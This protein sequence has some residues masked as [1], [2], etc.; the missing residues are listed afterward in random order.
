MLPGI[1][2]S[3]WNGA[4]DW[5]TVVSAGYKFAYTKATDSITYT[6]DTLAPNA[7]GAAEAGI[8][9]GAYHFYR[10]AADAKA[11]AEYFLAKIK[12]LQMEMP[13]VLDF[14]EQASFPHATVAKSLKL[15]LD[16][17]EAGTG[18]K[19]IIYTSAYYWNTYA[20]TPSWAGDYA[21]WVANYTAAPQP[22]L[23]KGWK[24]YLIWQFS[25]KGMVPGITGDVDLNRF[26][27]DEKALADL[28][29]R[30]FAPPPPPPPGLEERV[31]VLENQLTA[32]QDVLRA[33]GLL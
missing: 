8:P 15:W 25:D 4:I 19:P 11:Q 26:N 5:K 12:N 13:P 10:L 14:E 32:L 33:K 6:D 16:I 17:V 28:T 29:G 20:G 24:S 30:Q 9:I 7:A 3:H 1:D 23:P 21:L 18:R 27:G 31:K 22:L 2:V